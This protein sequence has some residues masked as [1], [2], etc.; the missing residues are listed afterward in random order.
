MDLFDQATYFGSHIP[1]KAITNPLLKHAACAYAAKQLGR[2]NGTKPIVGGPCSKQA[3][4]EG[5][6]G[7]ENEDFALVA[8]RHY[9]NA[10]SLLMEALNW[11]RGTSE[12]NSSEEIDK[13]QYAPR[14][15]EGM[16]AERRLRRRLFGSAQSTAG[17]DDLL[18]ATTILCGYEY[19][20]AS[21]AAWARHLSGTKSL[22]DVVE[23]GIMPLESPTTSGPFSA[24]RN[25]R[26]PSQARKAIFWEFARQD[27]VA[28]F[29]NEC[30]TRL[31]TDDIAM[32]KEAGLLLDENNL[33]IPSN[34]TDRGISEDGL[35]R[36]DMIG[37][38]LVWL[39]SKLVITRPYRIY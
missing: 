36:E 24:S 21:N 5:W 35:M 25:A 4:M 33:V 20:D 32:W 6:D 3:S 30:R 8:A 39:S 29:I 18:A 27:F 11:D 19:L 10:I 2:V 26:K 16:V 9:E 28:A 37:N 31:D 7:P 12:A 23:V 13:R 1:V 22:L 34:S 15:L 17:S 14:T 38:A